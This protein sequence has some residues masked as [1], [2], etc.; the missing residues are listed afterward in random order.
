MVVKIGYL[1]PELYDLAEDWM[2]ALT[3]GGVDQDL[4]RLGHKKIG[5]QMWPF[6][7]RFEAEPDLKARVVGRGWVE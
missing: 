7:S 2:L 1:E 6:D 4:R 3:L 5:R